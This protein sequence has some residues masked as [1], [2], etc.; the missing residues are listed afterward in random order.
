MPMAWKNIQRADIVI[1]TS[2]ITHSKNATWP[3]GT[4]PINIQTKQ[5][6]ARNVGK[7]TKIQQTN[8][9]KRPRRTRKNTSKTS[10][11]I[12]KRHCRK[13]TKTKKAEKHTKKRKNNESIKKTHETQETPPTKR[14]KLIPISG[15]HHN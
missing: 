8:G 13:G 3:I 2:K 5:Q 7:N 6:N 15:K 1:K 14:I 4:C 12:Q 11:H 10:K 9:N